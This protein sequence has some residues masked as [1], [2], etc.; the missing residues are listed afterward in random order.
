LGERGEEP[1]PQTL[2]EGLCN[3]FEQNADERDFCA[4]QFVGQPLTIISKR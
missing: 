2:A 3:R 1:Q 4:A